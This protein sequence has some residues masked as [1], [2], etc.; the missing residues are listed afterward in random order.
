MS[1]KDTGKVTQEQTPSPKV[2][3]LDPNKSQAHQKTPNKERP[4]KCL[5]TLAQ[6]AGITFDEKYE[7]SLTMEKSQS[8]AQQQQQQQAA[9]Q[10]QQQQIQQTQHLQPF[11]FTADQ[12]PQLQQIVNAYAQQGQQTIQVKQEYAT[13]QQPQGISA[14]DLKSLQDQQ[15]QLQQMQIVQAEA[16]QS[17]HQNSAQNALQQAVQNGQVPAEYLQQR[18]QVLPQSLQNAQYLT[19]QMYGPQL[20]MSGNLLTHSGLGQQPQIQ[21]IAAGK[22]FQNQLTPQMLTTAGGKPVQGFSSYTIPSNQQQTLL[23]SPVTVNGVL[24]S[25]NQQQQNNQQQ[26]LSS[27]QAQNTPT[28]QEGQKN[29]GQKVVQKV[30]NQGVTT[31]QQQQ[32]ANAQQ[33]ASNQQTQQCVQVSQTMPTAQILSG[34]AMQFSASP[35]QFQNMPFWATSNGLQPQTLQLAS[36][37]IFIRGTNPDGTPVL[38]QQSPQPQATQQTVQQSPHNRKL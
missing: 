19:Q 13:Q 26:I 8:P 37:P 17:P 20:V 12:F 16:P 11:Q 10:Q 1:V 30:G 28:K 34:Q 4:L 31:N 35:W 9:Q 3:N 2:E 29:M 21:L 25:Q 27:M 36:N 6:K 5:E 15:N 14:A 38:F 23:F 22:Q 32:Q 33:A 18:V 7:T 24:N